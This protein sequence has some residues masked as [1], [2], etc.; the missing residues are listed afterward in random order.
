MNDRLTRAGGRPAPN[1]RAP[2]ACLILTWLTTCLAP[3]LLAPLAARAAALQGTPPSQGS[4][5]NAADT[6]PL[7]P[8]VKEVVRMLGAKVSEA[9]ILQWID[10]PGHHPAKVGSREVIELKRAGASDALAKKLI[11]AAGKPAAAGQPPAVAVGAAAQTPPPAPKPPERRVPPPHAAPL[12]WTIEYHPNFAQD[13]VAWD[14]YVYLDGHY[15]AWVKAPL[16]SFL[17]KP[18]EFD[19]SLAPGHHVLRLVEER[20]ERKADNTGWSN[21]ARVA[22]AALTFDLVPDAAGHV[23]IHCE[24]RRRGG[25]MSM[26]VD[27]SGRP[28]QHTQPHI[29]QPETWPALCEEIL[30]SDT[31][32]KDPRWTSQRAL[33]VCLHWSDLW[34]ASVDP[35]SRDD[36]R[37][38]LQRQSFHPG[39]EADTPPS[40]AAGAGSGSGSGSGSS[41]APAPHP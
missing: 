15:L 3:P 21:E 24:V 40:P 4:A 31:A 36:V 41:P 9:V 33:N 26:E 17:D 6:V 7:D 18:L 32:G 20:H 29:G 22:P 11:E 16:V 5:P 10:L 13:D 37:D 12:H 8:A 30:L 23:S 27:Q 14:L 34:P 39:A 25:P 19:R 35:P 2:L 1:R 38:D 28:T